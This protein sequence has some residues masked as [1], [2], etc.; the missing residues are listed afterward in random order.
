MEQNVA[1]GYDV[2]RVTDTAPVRDRCG[3]AVVAEIV[4]LI[5]NRPLKLL[6][7]FLSKQIS[8]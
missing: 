2:P 7:D 4:L 6:K 1:R 3:L 5:Q 8:W